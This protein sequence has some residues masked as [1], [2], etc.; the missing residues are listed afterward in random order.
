[1]LRC[2]PIAR[3]A[4][5]Y[6]GVALRESEQSMISI[7]YYIQSSVKRTPTV[8]SEFLYQWFIIGLFPWEKQSVTTWTAE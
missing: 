8:D 1:M 3:A 7:E 2:R 4:G 6:D 5:K